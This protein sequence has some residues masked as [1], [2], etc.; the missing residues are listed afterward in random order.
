MIL[1]FT[2]TLTNSL[3]LFALTII[4]IHNIYT[5]TCNITTIEGQ[6]IS[7]HE[8]LVRRARARGGHLDGPDGL[9]IRIVKQEF[10]YDIG[11]YRNARQAMGTSFVTWLWPFA[12]TPSN[13]TGYDFE[14]NGFE[15]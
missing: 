1:L 13:G 5:L 14:T 2:L 9:K 3:T 10:P 7:R 12:S 6:E 4:L 11:F 8:T 15:G